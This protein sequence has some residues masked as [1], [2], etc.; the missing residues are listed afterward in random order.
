MNMTMRR[1]A[2]VP[3]ASTV[4]R[5][6]LLSS[7]LLFPFNPQLL[8]SG[9]P[10]P[11]KEMERKVRDAVGCSD[12]YHSPSPPPSPVASARWRM[13]RQEKE[14]EGGGRRRREEMGKRSHR[15]KYPSARARASLWLPLPAGPPPVRVSAFQP[16]S[17]AGRGLPVR[18]APSSPSSKKVEK[19]AKKL[20]PS[21]ILN[22]S[23]PSHTRAIYPRNILDISY[24]TTK[25]W[26]DC[27]KT[28]SSSSHIP[29]PLTI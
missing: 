12:D 20:L 6:R 7:P 28:I 10:W 1:V 18:Y 11:G 3:H 27:P 21:L 22:C 17:N 25:Y 2:M 29:P 16:R 5:T 8:R 15:E 24:Q 23:I 9:Q 4:C 13:A 26:P 19:E 14:G